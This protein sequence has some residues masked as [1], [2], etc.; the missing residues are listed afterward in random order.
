MALQ[1][2]Y[3]LRDATAGPRAIAARQALEQSPDYDGNVSDTDLFN[4]IAALENNDFNPP[5]NDNSYYGNAYD[6][7]PNATDPLFNFAVLR[8][9]NEKEA[10]IWGME[11]AV[12][13]LWDEPGL[14]LAVN[15][16]SVNGDVGFDSS[17]HPLSRQFALLGLSDTLNA[18]AF[19]EKGNIQCRLAYHWRDSYLDSL[20]EEPSFVD[21]YEQVDFL[22][23]Y[24]FSEQLVLSFEVLNLT[25]EDKRSF[26][27]SKAQLNEYE[28]LDPRY[29]LGLR[30][31]F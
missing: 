13:W 14:G 17:A 26:G 7:Y 1:P 28:Q 23:A 3:E 11:Y 2:V 12:Q 5:I 22:F 15:Y 9:A 10:R 4:Q 8:P 29:Y 6:I 27:R 30:Y 24:S 18:M 21:A 20:A 31:Q 16:T 19:Y 25:G